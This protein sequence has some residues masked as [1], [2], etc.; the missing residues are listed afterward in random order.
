MICGYICWICCSS[1]F[2]GPRL[3]EFL[4]YLGERNKK[5]W[6]DIAQRYLKQPPT[7][8]FPD[9]IITI[10]HNLKCWVV[11][12]RFPVLGIIRDSYD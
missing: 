10:I 9:Y 11:L 5:S 1:I 4:Y 6:G 3:Y 7:R 8:E 2:L 12:V